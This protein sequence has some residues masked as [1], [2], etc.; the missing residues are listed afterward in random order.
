MPWRQTPQIGHREVSDIAESGVGVAAR[1]EVDLDQAHARQ[2]AG[3]DVVDVA[4]EGKKTLER[5]S[6]V[7]LD[8][9]RRHPRVKSRN[10]NHRNLDLRE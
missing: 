8:L 6:D 7:S 1:L 4:A 2:R 10:H 5:I 3:L 9:L